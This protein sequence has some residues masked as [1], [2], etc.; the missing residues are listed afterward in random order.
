MSE[1]QVQR[2]E[3][4]EEFRWWKLEGGFEWLSMDSS[5]LPRA[6]TIEEIELYNK[7]QAPDAARLVDKDTLWLV[8]VMD[9]RY[10]TIH[11][12]NPLHEGA[13]H[14]DTLHDDTPLYRKFAELELSQEAIKEFA[15]DHGLLFRAESMFLSTRKEER[16]RSSKF[17]IYWA[18]TF[19][20]WSKEIEAMSDTTALWDLLH[21][22]YG[23]PDLGALKQVILWTKKN[24][25]YFPRRL[26]ELANRSS[27]YARTMRSIRESYDSPFVPFTD[28]FCISSPNC[29]DRLIEKWRENHDL[30]GPAKQYLKTA[31]NKRLNEFVAP[32][33]ELSESRGNGVALH[34]SLVPRNLLGAIWL[35]LF[36]ETTRSRKTK[37]C[38]LCGRWFNATEHPRQLYCRHRASGCRKRAY[39]IRDK[40]LTGTPPNEVAEK[41][42]I[43]LD[44]LN[45]ILA[46]ARRKRSG[47]SH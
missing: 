6:L 16:S 13:S 4:G 29:P 21:S 41:E 17:E 33:L 3:L 28:E 12:Y 26:S 45:A 46:T 27:S 30:V 18:E 20:Q 5:R 39:R 10:E 8:G 15:N 22:D 43:S 1:I 23:T 47:Q 34:A 42:G 9:L 11:P 19:S 32:Q 2:Q 31:A 36:Q 35:Q 7:S 44:T 24:A 40:V 37:K 38:L 25:W 14:K